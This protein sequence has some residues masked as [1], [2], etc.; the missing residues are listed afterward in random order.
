MLYILFGST[1]EMGQR[2]RDYFQDNGFPLIEK[3]NYVPRR[4]RLTT[5]F[6]SRTKATK[7]QVEACDYIYENGG[8]KVG[9]NKSQILDAVSGRCNRLLTLSAPTFDFIREIKAAY[10][11]YVTVIGTYI[12]PLQLEKM[13]RAN[14]SVSRKERAFRLEIGENVK[15]IMLE[16]RELFD[17]IIL[18]GGEHSVFNLDSLG[19]Q[20]SLIISKAEKRQRRMNDMTYVDLPYK[21]PKPYVFISYSHDDRNRVLPILR[22]LQLARCRVWYDDGIKGGDNWR[23]TLA[24]KIRDPNCVGV[25]L[26]SSKKSVSSHFVSEEVDIALECHRRIITVRLDDAIFN[27]KTETH[28]QTY[29]N[30]F[31]QDQRFEE[32]LIEAIGDAAIMRF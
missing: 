27:Y 31:S 29:Q 4:V 25:V 3:L 19:S 23:V 1:A 11:D 18:Y 10:G 24:D 22:L 2:C 20:L 8:L 9:F 28:L 14:R 32:K 13:Y 6:G 26:F 15:R 12:D 21:G 30:L 17:E 16:N 7:K 5:L